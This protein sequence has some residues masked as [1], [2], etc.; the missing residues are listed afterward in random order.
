M[1]L[2]TANLTIH[3]LNLGNLRPFRL[4]GHPKRELQTANFDSNLRFLEMEAA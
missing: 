2:L 3:V 1:A 4:L